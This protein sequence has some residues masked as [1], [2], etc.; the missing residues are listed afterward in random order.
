MN[1]KIFTFYYTNNY[2]AQLQCLALKEFLQENFDLKIE[3]ARYIPKKLLFREIYSPMITK[4]S[5]QI[6]S[7]L[8]KKLLL[9]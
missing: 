5:I 2:G 8:K 3:C 9:W 6:L 1:I 4:Q 7:I